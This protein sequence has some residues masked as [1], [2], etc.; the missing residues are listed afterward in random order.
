[1]SSMATV[2]AGTTTARSVAVVCT[3]TTASGVATSTYHLN[4]TAEDDGRYEVH[5]EAELHVTGA[6]GWRVTPNP[7]HGELEFCDLWVEGSFV[8]GDGG[9]KR[10]Q[11]H[12]VRRAGDVVLIPHH[13]CESDDKHNILMHAGDEAAWLTEDDN[14]V[15][16]IESSSGV[17]AGICAYMW[18]MHF[19]YTV[20]QGGE[21]VTLP[22]GFI[23]RARFSLRSMPR[24]EA[25][26]WLRVART[27]RP[28]GLADVPV[29]VRGVHTFTDTF[30]SAD[31]TRTDL[32]PWAF[33]VLEGGRTLVEGKIDREVGFDDSAS[34]K[35]GASAGGRGRWVLTTIGPAFSGPPFIPGRHYRLSARVRTRGGT[36]TVALAL[37]RSDAPG[38]YDPSGYE[39]FT[40]QTRSVEN[41]WALVVVETPPIA[42]APDRVHCRLYHAG[43]GIG[44]FDNVLFEEY[45]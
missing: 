26:L 8:P 31:L 25:D 24:N 2:T 39:E 22:R 12:A 5:V 20:C 44:W 41:G 30:A 27:A 1:M 18:D 45:D 7:H 40:G 14:P 32:W 21:P 33:E 15:V 6:A 3:G 43:E 34:L 28:G 37:H 19:A 23:A 17:A 38:V 4:V 42:P 16:R 35:I 9:T 29:H 13:H 11:R 10:Y 36:A